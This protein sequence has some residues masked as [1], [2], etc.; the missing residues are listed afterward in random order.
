MGTSYAQMYDL[1]RSE[2][3]EM[4][5]L[6]SQMLIGGASLETLNELLLLASRQK[7][8]KGRVGRILQQTLK[9]ALESFR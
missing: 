4:C 1:S 3:D 9:V 5:E 2:P 6:V 7:P 8:Q